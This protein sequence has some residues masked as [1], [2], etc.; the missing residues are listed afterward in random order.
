MDPWPLSEK[1][2]KSLQITHRIHG[3]AIYGNMDPINIPQL[4]AYIPAPWILWVI[5]NYTYASPTSFQNLSTTGST[6][7]SHPQVGGWQG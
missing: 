4:L 1:V 5:V 3:S 2:Q 7:G 6:W